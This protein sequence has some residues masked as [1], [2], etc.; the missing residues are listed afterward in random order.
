ME[1]ENELKKRVVWKR[2]IATAIAVGIAAVSFIGGYFTRQGLLDDGM[3]VLLDVKKGVQDEYY[4]PVTDEE[5]YDAALQ[6]INQ[7]LLDRYS[8]YMTKEQWNESTA[9]GKGKYKGVGLAFSGTGEGAQSLFIKRVAGNSSAENAGMKAGSYL[10]GYSVGTDE[11]MQPLDSYDSLIDV[12]D[13]REMDETFYLYTKTTLDGMQTQKYQV[14]KRAYT[15]CYVYYRSNT[16]AYRYTGKNYSA[17]AFGDSLEMLSNDTAYIKLV[18][19]NGNADEEFDNAMQT[20]KDE[21]K[22]NLVLD[23]RGN[24]GGYMSIMQRIAKYFCKNATE[25]KPVAVYAQY[26]NATSV[27]KADGNVYNQYFD[28]DSKIY[29]LADSSTASASECLL[30][31]MLDYGAISYADICL[32]TRENVAKTYGKGIM[33][34]TFPLSLIRGDALKVT[35]AYVLWPSKNCIHDR[36]I[37]PTDG[38]KTVAENLFGDTEIIQALQA[39]GL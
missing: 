18:Q 21:G 16:N 30:G 15:E 22:K 25:D 33:Q 28:E 39:F 8:Q 11:P 31:V 6:G 1:Q 17:Y 12:L 20:F 9:Q 7:F 23:L 5:F 24:G 13:A 2:V 19:F 32:S 4:K 29:V 35:T 3:Q 36:G 27:Y 38:T 14:E 10:V 37:L 34:V 26:A